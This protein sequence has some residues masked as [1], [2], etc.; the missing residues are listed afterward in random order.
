[1]APELEVIT[2]PGI[3][4]YHAACARL[5]LPVAEGPEGFQ[6]ISGINGQ[7]DLEAALRRSDT[8]FILKA[9]RNFPSIKEAIK[10]LGLEDNTILVKRL[11]LDGE[12]V[13]E[14]I[15]GIAPT[16]KMPYFTLLIV[17][18][19]TPKGGENNGHND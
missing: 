12:G 4:S 11:Y 18:K 8:I 17:K 13:V 3:T 1:M 7:K 14:G 10:G 6:V 2:I 16:E 19:R 9:Y 5:N 15:D